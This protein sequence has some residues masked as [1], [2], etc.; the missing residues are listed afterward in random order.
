M[1]LLEQMVTIASAQGIAPGGLSF[2][3]PWAVP[4]PEYGPTNV[5]FSLSDWHRGHIH[6]CFMVGEE[7]SG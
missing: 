1:L 7:P 3:V 5:A 6:C 2:S 4:E